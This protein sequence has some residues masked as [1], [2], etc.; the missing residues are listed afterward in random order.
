MLQNLFGNKESRFVAG[1]SLFADKLYLVKAERRENDFHCVVATEM[2]IA[3]EDKIPEVLTQVIREFQL[4]QASTTLILPPNKLQSTQIEQ[5]EM[6]AAEPEVALPWK[7]KDLINIPPQ[8][9]ICDFVDQPLQPTGQQPK[10]QVVA[11]SKKYLESLIAPFHEAKAKISAITNEQFAI[12]K[13]QETQNAAQLIFIQR[14]KADGILLIVKNQEICF[15]RKIRNTA[16]IIEMTPEQIQ[17]GGSDTIAVEIQR[18][19]DF[20]ESQLKQPPIKN[21]LIA[22]AG[23]NVE[24]LIT[25]LNK[26]LPV[27]SKLIPLNNIKS[28]TPIDSKF[29]AA[30]GGA[31][32][33]REMPTEVTSEN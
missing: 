32:Y 15:G 3:S 17:M 28:D 2:P 30:V 18:S 19:I 31:I 6:P 20:Y 23:E 24:A 11:T 25:E 1:V 21:A 4:E 27:K 14:Q 26:V 33:M 5:S 29:I 12:A 7:V 9:M 8:D 22:M 13:L 16:G 10:V